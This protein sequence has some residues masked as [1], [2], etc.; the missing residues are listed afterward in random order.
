MEINYVSAFVFAF[1]ATCGFGFIIQVPFKA[2]PTSGIIGAIGWVVFVYISKG[3]G[4]STVYANFTATVVVAVLSELFAR[5]MKQPV[6]VYVIPGVI[7]LV[8]GLGMYNGMTKILSRH[9]EYGM[10]ILMQACSDAGAIAMG[11]MLVTSIF[12]M[13]KI[14]K[15][16]KSIAELLKRQK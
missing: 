4:H 1:I 3:F 6:N 5:L 13:I 15:E 12:R 9:F 11:M 7:P 2:I 16:Q 14:S 8:P 10:S